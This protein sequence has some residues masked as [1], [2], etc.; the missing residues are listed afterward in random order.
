MRPTRL[1]ITA[2]RGF[3]CR[4]HYRHQI[5]AVNSTMDIIVDTGIP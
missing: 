1:L 2:G 3:Y 5:L 4:F